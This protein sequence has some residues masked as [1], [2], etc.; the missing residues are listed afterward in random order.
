MLFNYR[1]FAYEKELSSYRRFILSNEPN[2]RDLASQ[3]EFKFNFNPNFCII[4]EKEE[5]LFKESLEQQTYNKFVVATLNNIKEIDCDYYVICNSFLSL[6][7]NFLFEIVS[8]LNK[9]RD[10]DFFYFDEDRVDEKGN[11]KEP[12]FKVDFS[13]DTLRSCNYI[14]NAIC[15]SKKIFEE[16]GL[17]DYIDDKESLHLYD[18]ILRVSEKTKN[19]SHISKILIH[20]FED[21]YKFDSDKDKKAIS[22]HLDRIGLNGIV[23]DGFVSETYKIEYKIK[24]N[25]L[26]SIIIPNHN[27][28]K[29]LETCI[30]SI[31]E[32]TTYSN[33]EI[34]IVENHS[35][36]EGI[37]EY[38]KELEK[39]SNI[40]I[41]IYSDKFN[42]ASVN[43]FAVKESKGDYL[44]LLN[45]D[46]ELLTPSWIEEMLIYA[47]R[48]DVGAVGVKLYYPDNTIQHVGIIFGILE[49]VVHQL[50]YFSKNSSGY[51]NNFSVVQN[52]SCATGA[53]IMSSRK[54]YLEVGGLD[55][56]FKISFNDVDYCLKLRNK[57]Y[58]VIFNPFV[59]AI[60]NECS[61][62]GFNDTEEKI[63]LFQ[64]EKKIFLDKWGNYT[65]P[66]YN[67]N[68]TRSDWDFSIKKKSD[69]LYFDLYMN[70]KKSWSYRIGRA[71]TYPIFNL[72]KFFSSIIKYFK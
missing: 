52:L 69:S 60:H 51:G 53:C 61:T 43:N 10:I 22:D 14:G 39:V 7:P 50:R 56:R 2:E 36:D 35:T 26:V 24:G 21:K 18:I 71:I 46:V 42:Y 4:T 17:L 47:Q 25:P 34:L 20:I 19:I 72:F 1:E 12:F 64:K 5:L 44:I 3:K 65:E 13:P 8:E 63:E 16:I 68:L 49:D 33:Y 38:Y 57:D 40:K 30:N 66:Y 48:D 27:H 45:N 58:F 28:K 54:K 31:I 23:K 41:L 15:I 29:D 70:L 55:E 37:F 11:R 62:R 9:N 59:E 67:E 6:A 32:K